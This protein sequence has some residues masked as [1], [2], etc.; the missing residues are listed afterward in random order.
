M[1]PITR[2]EFREA[3]AQVR[4]DIKGV[5]TRLDALNGRVRTSEDAIARLQERLKW[6]ASVGQGRRHWWDRLSSGVAVAT[7][8]LMLERV[9]QVVFK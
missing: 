9:V 8:T 1:E 4:E 5:H 2:E 7:A 3:I 6:F